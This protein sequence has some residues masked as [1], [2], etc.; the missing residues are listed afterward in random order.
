[1]D[2]LG[3]SKLETVDSLILV[4]TD[5]VSHGSAAA[6]LRADDNRDAAQAGGQLMA[7][8][9]EEPGARD[10][11][12]AEAIVSTRRSSGGCGSRIPLEERAPLS[13]GTA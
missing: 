2:L 12:T 7:V 10:T 11:A 6:L 1:M 8:A 3:A 5:R 9:A 13:D 4:A